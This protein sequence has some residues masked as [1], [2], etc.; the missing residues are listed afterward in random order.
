MAVR[1]FDTIAGMK[2]FSRQTRAA[3]KS[4]GFVPTMGALHEG[5]L[6][7]IRQAKRQCDVVVVS[8]Y[9]NPT[10]FGPHE[11]LARYPS[12]L[13]KD[14]EVLI[15]FKLDAVFTPSTGEMFPKGLQTYIEPGEIASTLEGASRPGHFRGVATVVAK[16]FN[17]VRPDIAYFGQKDFQQVLVVRRLVEDLNLDVRLV[18]CPT[19]RE[20][21]GLARSSRNLLLSEREREIA[22]VLYRSLRRAESL[23]HLGV[24]SAQKVRQEILRAF[25][26]EPEARLDYAAIVEPRELKP[27]E[28]IEAGTV[29]LVA[30][31]V[32]DTRLID[33]LIF[34]PPGATPE[35]LLQ[36]ALSAQRVTDAAARIPGLETETLRLRIER[37][38]ECA[39]I[40]SVLLPPREFLAK[41]L[42]RDYPDLNAV[43]VAVIGRNSPVN[44]ESFLYRNPHSVDRFN[45]ALFELVGVRDFEEF[46]SRFILTDS[47]RCHATDTHIPEKALA[48]CARHLRDELNLFPN[49]ES[50]VLLGEDAFVQF[51]RFLRGRPLCEIPPFA[52]LLRDQGWA[53]EDLELPFL[54]DRRLKVFYC[55][56][57][58]IGYTRSPSIAPLL[59]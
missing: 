36:L 12:D 43:R 15:P 47:T 38:R 58:T 59:R 41:Y 18:V 3:G 20:A 25:E 42:Q 1:V 51:Q 57:P 45:Q 33:N 13:K 40:S 48:A 32:G 31:R 21:E 5:H 49:L 7:L 54:G 44:P 4:L 50:I 8:I 14:L 55:Y 53:R 26:E 9:L 34:G 39:A 19:V 22:L 2:A 24:V 35:M 27:V 11:D 6:S 29:A 30:A 37:C 46:R 56:H 17:I 52:T 23:V 16:L 10:Q 28:R